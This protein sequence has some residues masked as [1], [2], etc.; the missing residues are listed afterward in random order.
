MGLLDSFRKLVAGQ[1]YVDEL[2]SENDRQF[3]S[4]MQRVESIN[5]LEEE[6]EKLTDE[7]LA[8]QSTLFRDRL[9]R[10]EGLDALLV[11][12][13]AVAREAAWRVLELR[14]FDVQVKRYYQYFSLLPDGHRRAQQGNRC[15]QRIT[16]PYFPVDA[17]DGR[18]GSARGPAGRDG[19]GRGQ[20]ARCGEHTLLYL[21]LYHVH[22]LVIAAT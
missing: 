13:F 7:S 10:G 21:P 8:R 4:Y 20:V 12:A 2:K 16:C 1:D 14:P 19:H 5:A 17:A 15:F 6:I 3:K 9:Q 18:Y 11:E 22:P